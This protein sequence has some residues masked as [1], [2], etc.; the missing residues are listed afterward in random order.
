MSG[1][2]KSR[3]SV[4]EH[5]CEILDSE[6]IR[7]GEST[8]VVRTARGHQKAR[9][10]C[11]FVPYSG[12]IAQWITHR[13]IYSFSKLLIWWKEIICISMIKIKIYSL[14]TYYISYYLL[15]LCS[16]YLMYNVV[17]F[18][19]CYRGSH[20]YFYS[21]FTSSAKHHAP[22]DVTSE[23]LNAVCIFLSMI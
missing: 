18:A 23:Y 5:G 11:T 21:T 7:S 16:I 4:M 22:N 14:S 17:A 10:S 2:E 19:R 6:K 20:S 3:A 1:R 12:T 13:E 8:G 15:L 9:G